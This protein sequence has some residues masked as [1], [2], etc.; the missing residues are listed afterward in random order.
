MTFDIKPSPFSHGTSS[1]SL[2]APSR[3]PAEFIHILRKS[4][5]GK[6]LY[7]QAELHLRSLG[8]ELRIEIVSFHEMLRRYDHM[9]TGSFDHTSGII[10]IVE[11]INDKYTLDSLIFELFNASAASELRKIIEK[12]RSRKIASPDSY[13]LAKLELERNT[14]T[15]RNAALEKIMTS[16]AWKQ[17]KGT[18]PKPLPLG[19]DIQEFCKIHPG[20]VSAYKT[21]FYS[22]A[23]P[24]S[25]K[26]CI[27]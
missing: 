2:F 17:L 10:R 7:D 4:K 23:S 8:L 14:A 15:L 26:C 27:L 3:D 1:S 19:K 16:K 11:G 9:F 18:D 12:T 24:S 6:K 5:T 21:Q 22:I 25:S 13:A 20:H